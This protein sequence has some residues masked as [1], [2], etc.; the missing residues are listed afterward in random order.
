MQLYS[1]IQF[2]NSCKCTLMWNYHIQRPHWVPRNS[3]SPQNFA[4]GR[5]D[6]QNFFRH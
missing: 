2:A 4:F 6:S 5:G 1:Y 3:E